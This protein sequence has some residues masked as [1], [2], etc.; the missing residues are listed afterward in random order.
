MVLE[1]IQGV[2][3]D[4]QACTLP[5]GTEYTPGICIFCGKPLDEES[6]GGYFYGHK[7][8]AEAYEDK[9]RRESHERLVASCPPGTRF[10]LAG[11]AACD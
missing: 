9:C 11:G 5:D 2:K 6:S 1:Q 7:R 4:M 8:C 10:D 3:M